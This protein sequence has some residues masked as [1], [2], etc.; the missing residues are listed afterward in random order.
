MPNGARIECKAAVPQNK[1]VKGAS[2]FKNP[3]D[4]SFKAHVIE[5]YQFYEQ[6]CFTCKGMS[7]STDQSESRICKLHFR[8]Y[9]SST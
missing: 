1:Q 8:Q 6:K 7:D 3:Q 2:K 4:L 5:L 9:E